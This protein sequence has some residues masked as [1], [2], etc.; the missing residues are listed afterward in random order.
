MRYRGLTYDPGTEK[1][2]YVYGMPSY[3]FETEEVSEIGTP[4]G[5]FY[6]INPATLGEETHYQDRNGKRIYTGD[7]VTL[8]VD[9]EVREFVVEKATIDREYKVLPGFEGNTVKVRLSNVIVFC[10]T[11]PDGITHKLL[12]CVNEKGIDDTSFME[13]VDTIHERTV[14]ESEG[15]GKKF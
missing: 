2:R 12:P 10:W 13:I 8:E 9:G 6:E 4:Y 15:K 11:S 3:G 1:H 7:I 14:R 5:D